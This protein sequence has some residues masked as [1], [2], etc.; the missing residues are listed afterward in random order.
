MPKK[1]WAI[2]KNNTLLNLPKNDK[3]KPITAF[4]SNTICIESNLGILASPNAI[5]IHAK[6]ESR[7]APFGKLLWNPYL[8]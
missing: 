6:G 2:Q 5:L 8:E 7:A 4:E 3:L 1:E